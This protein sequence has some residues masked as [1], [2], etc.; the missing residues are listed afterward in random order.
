MEDKKKRLQQSA[1]QSKILPIYMYT[2]GQNIKWLE[3]SFVLRQVGIRGKK[4]GK[5]IEKIFRKSPVRVVIQASKYFLSHRL[6]DSR[7]LS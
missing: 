4:R 6:Q 3:G 7:I 5:Y 1:G 2:A